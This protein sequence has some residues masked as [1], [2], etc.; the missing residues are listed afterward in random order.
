MG[1][2]G[3]AGSSWRL[4]GGSLRLLEASGRLLETP[5][6]G[7][8]GLLEAA[9]GRFWGSSSL[10]VAPEGSGFFGGPWTGLGVA[11]SSWGCW[12]L[13][14]GSWRHL[15]I[16]WLL[17]PEQGSSCKAPG[18]F[19][20]YWRLLGAPGGSG[21]LLEASGGSWGYWSQSRASEGSWRFLT[22][23]WTLLQLLEQRRH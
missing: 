17:E 3:A 1:L 21:R 19:W 20:S 4:L 2:P 8:W 15:E 18:S 16:L 10:L 12:R 6:Q 11:G 22:G 7:S 5:E 13:L 9:P 14:F 23:C